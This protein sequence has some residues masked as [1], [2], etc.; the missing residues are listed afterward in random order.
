MLKNMVTSAVFAGFG[1]GLIAALLQIML[2]VPVILEAEL[3]ES[4]ARVHFGSVSESHSPSSHTQSDNEAEVA[5]SNLS[6]NGQT[7]LWTLGTYLGL[8]L[9]V[10]AGFA[11]ARRYGIEVNARSGILWG[12]A[13]F[14]AFHLAPATGL[15]PELPGN[16]SADLFVRQL[17]WTMTV[18]LSAI[19][20]AAI[21]YGKNWL[22]WGTGILLLLVPHFI[23]APDM[24]EF[25]GVSPP[26]LA[27]KFVSLSMAVGAI[28]W[29]CLGFFA[30]FFWSNNSPM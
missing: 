1:A 16:L 21:G 13:G 5:P 2:I 8:A 19:A 4:G 7:V 9:V 22:I 27:G 18:I 14:V 17:W 20:L 6:R 10:V 11:I 25:G 28:G 30:G 26:E 15:P 29:V 12:A 23:G 3:Y 24:S